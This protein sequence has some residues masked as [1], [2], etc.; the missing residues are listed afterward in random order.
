[1][2]ASVPNSKNLFGVIV[3]KEF[4]GTKFSAAEISAAYKSIGLSQYKPYLAHGS[5]VKCILKYGTED[6]KNKYLPLLASGENI[7][8]YC[9]YESEQGYDIQ[10]TNTKA[11]FHNNHWVINGSK[12]WVVNAKQADTLLIIAK[13]MDECNRPENNIQFFSAFLVKKSSI[14]ITVIENGDHC[15]VL[16]NNV[17]AECML[18]PENEGLLLYSLL[19]NSDFLESASAT[20]GEIKKITKIISQDTRFKNPLSITK[21]GHIYSNLFSMNCI[22]NF[23]NLLLDSLKVDDYEQ[24]L[25]RLFVTKA[26]YACI[27]LFDDLGLPKDMYEHIQ[28]SLLFDGRGNL[29]IYVGSLLGIQYAG[30]FMAND[31][32]QLRNPLMFPKYT[33]NHIIKIQKSLK[34][35]PKLRNF[36]GQYLHPSLKKQASDLEYCLSRLQFAVQNMFINLGPD[37]FHYQMVLER[38]NSVALNIYAMTAILHY[39]SEHLS[40][41]NSQIYPTEL[42]FANVFCN[43]LRSQCSEKVNEILNSPHNVTDPLYKSLAQQLFVEKNYFLEHPLKRNIF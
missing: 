39:V 11:S 8:T 22:L 36:L 27:D 14:G 38:V 20:V 21:F 5:V 10:N 25:A 17:K 34:D 16:F 42:V 18:G 19:F 2:H 23:T 43:T 31:I 7:A 15:D 24:I 6:Q 9:L 26:A 13:T 32:K 29:L 3:P 30:Q 4:G 12:N 37:T 40:K 35:K 1:K 28:N 33:L 41:S